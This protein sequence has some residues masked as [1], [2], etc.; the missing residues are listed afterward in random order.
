MK[1]KK[2]N[3]PKAIEKQKKNRKEKHQKAICNNEKMKELKI[4]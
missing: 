3:P 4:F 2:K 1:T